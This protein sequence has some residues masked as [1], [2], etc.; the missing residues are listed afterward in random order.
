MVGPETN[1]YLQSEA[2]CS[3]TRTPQQELRGCAPGVGGGDGH[4][5]DQGAGRGHQ[6]LLYVNC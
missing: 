3:D 4:C 1:C 5:G 6:V 2:G